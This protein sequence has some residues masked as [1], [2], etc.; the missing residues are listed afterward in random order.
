[1]TTICPGGI[2]ELRLGQYPFGR[3]Q[4]D[5]LMLIKCLGLFKRMDARFV[6]WP[7]Y[8]KSIFEIL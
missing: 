8:L 3:D 7:Q 4:I 2:L 5:A 1:V 6:K